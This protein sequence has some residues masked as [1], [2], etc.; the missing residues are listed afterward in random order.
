MPAPRPATAPGC[1]PDDSGRSP[2]TRS[3]ALPI[4]DA[5][6][7]EGIEKDLVVA[8][9]FDVLQTSAVTECVV[10]EIENV[11]GL[12]K[13]QVDLEQVKELVDGVDEADLSGQGVENAD[14]A[15]NEAAAAVGEVV[16]KMGLRQSPSLVLSRRRGCGPTLGG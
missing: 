16:V 14:A 12:V 4:G 15:V 13:G 11:I 9:Q 6:S 7:A 1:S 5:A 10:G 2:R 8:T 3:R